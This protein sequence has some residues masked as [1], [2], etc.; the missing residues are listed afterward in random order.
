MVKC[1]FVD[2]VKNENLMSS[3]SFSLPTPA[4]WRQPLCWPGTGF[5][6]PR[7]HVHRAEPKIWQ[8]QS[9]GRDRGD[10]QTKRKKNESQQ[11]FKDFFSLR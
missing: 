1:A 2:Q 3:P 11:C 8:F 6:K 4:V 10:R 5:D 7:S 9:L